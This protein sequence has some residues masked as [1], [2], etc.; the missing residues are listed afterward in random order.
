MP[1]ISNERLQMYFSSNGAQYPLYAESVQLY[2]ALR[3]HADGDFPKQMIEERRPSETEEILEY[4]KKTYKPITKGP[5]SRVITSFGKIRRSSDWTIDFPKDKISTRIP[6][7][8][9][10]C[11]Y[12]TNNLPGYGSITDWAFGILL[13]QN[14]LDSNAVIAVIPLEEVKNDTFTKPTPILFNSDQVIDFNEREKYCILRSKVKVN[15]FDDLN[16]IKQGDKFYYI[17]ENEIVIYEQGRNGYDPIFTQVNTTRQFPAFKVKGEAFKQYDNMSLNRSRMDAI[18]TFLDEAACEYSDLKG[19]KIQHLYPLF[20]YFQNKD[21]GT[22]N[23][24]GKISSEHGPVSCKTCG[25]GGKI[26]F[27]PFAHIEVT[28]PAVGS[29]AIPFSQPAGYI[30]RDTKILELQEA[31]VDKNIFRALAAIN[32]QF[33][34]QTPLSISGDAKQ[35]DREEL[36]NTVY[37]SAEDLIYSIDKAI[38]FINEWRYNYLVPDAVM[39]KSMLPNIP[40]PQNFDLLPEDYLMKEVTDARTAKINPLLI[41]TLEQQ[42]AAKKFY[43]Q[44]DLASNIKL[45]FDLD[46]LPGYGVDEKMSLISNKAITLEDF[47]I[48]SYM[49][50]FIKRAIREDKDFAKKEYKVQMDLLAKYAQEKIKANDE[51]AQMIEDQKQIIMDEMKSSGEF[52]PADKQAA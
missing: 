17:D 35:V 51:A 11:S 47:I 1:K 13:K 6:D 4:R 41:A 24:T 39:R 25:G 23:G 27:S 18:A 40:V 34:D 28:A 26:K 50:S 8:E 19:S 48:S 2:N 42:L 7:E 9:T 14:L 22:C 29:T 46:P 52:P 10:L 45:Y 16:N 12:C 5:I 37:N 21:C 44:P 20:W 15:Y 30:T 31:S 36:N 3:I 32:M 38:Y 43:N 49:A 33:L